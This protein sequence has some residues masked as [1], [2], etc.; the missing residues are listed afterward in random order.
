MW[1]ITRKYHPHHRNHTCELIEEPKEQCNRIFIDEK[2][3]IKI[4]IDC[5]TTSTHK[6]R[7]RLEFKQYDVIITKEQSVVTKTM[8]KLILC[9]GKCI[10]NGATCNL[11]QIWNNNTC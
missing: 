7:T 9:D 4:V 2:L 10:F 11:N 8:A 6:F 3:P 5:R 1:G